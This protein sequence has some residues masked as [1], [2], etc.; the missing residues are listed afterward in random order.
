MDIYNPDQLDTN[1]DGIGDECDY[2]NLEDYLLNKELIQVTD[3]LGRSINH[4]VKNQVLLY[5]YN[6]GTVIKSFQF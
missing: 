3:L 5:H 4:L 1:N 2:S 6:D